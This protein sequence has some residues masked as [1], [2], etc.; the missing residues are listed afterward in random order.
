MSF[1]AEL[2]DQGERFVGEVPAAKRVSAYCRDESPPADLGRLGMRKG[3]RLSNDMNIPPRLIAS[4]DLDQP[5]MF[6]S[7]LS[8]RWEGYA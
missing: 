4:L 2:V 6:D 5:F 7:A 1:L 3:I 8:V